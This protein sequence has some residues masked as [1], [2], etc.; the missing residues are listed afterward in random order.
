MRI[1]IYFIVVF[2]FNYLDLD[3]IRIF[4]KVNPLLSVTQ[5]DLDLHMTQMQQ[6]SEVS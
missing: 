2:G 4:I 1:G 5:S 6:K 3:Q